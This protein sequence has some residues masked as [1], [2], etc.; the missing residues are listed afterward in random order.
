MKNIMTTPLSSHSLVLIL[1]YKVWDTQITLVSVASVTNCLLVG[2][3]KEK[4]T[5]LFVNMYSQVIYKNNVDFKSILLHHLKPSLYPL[6]HK[7][8]LSEPQKQCFL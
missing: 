3:T 7:L 5:Q 6:S 8:K 1:S 2:T 4:C